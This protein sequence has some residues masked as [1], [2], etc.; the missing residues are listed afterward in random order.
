MFEPFIKYK[1]GIAKEKKEEGLH[2]AEKRFKSSDR[3][4]KEIKVG[5][6]KLYLRE[7]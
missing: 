5:H 4:L 7:I 3:R 2:Y 1:I 6:F